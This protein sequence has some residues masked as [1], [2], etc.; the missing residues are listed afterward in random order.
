[1][2]ETPLRFLP[3]ADWA[4]TAVKQIEPILAP[5]ARNA[6]QAAR[7][8]L[9]KNLRR[10]AAHGF[11]V[12]ITAPDGSP[13]SIYQ[14]F[15]SL[16]QLATVSFDEADRNRGESF[17]RGVLQVSRSIHRNIKAISLALNYSNP[18]FSTQAWLARMKAKAQA[19]RA[20]KYGEAR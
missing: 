16:F 11:T 17:S 2:T 13:D 5:D 14:G 4:E 1:M 7:F 9:P 12:D 3:A 19:A 10:L 6:S 8:F 20:A 18:E 15:D